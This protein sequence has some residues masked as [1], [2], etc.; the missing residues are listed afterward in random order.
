MTD[1][2]RE[3]LRRLLNEGRRSG[4]GKPV[5]KETIEALRE[6]A[7]CAAIKAAL[8]QADKAKFIS[9]EAVNRWLDS[10]GTENEL[11]PPKPDI[12]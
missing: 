11:P 12:T 4:S 10:W 1:D 2:D 7:K 8:E 9:A 6:R 3:A 5:D